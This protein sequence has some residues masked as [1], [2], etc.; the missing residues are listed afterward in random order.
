MSG[1]WQGRG[2]QQPTWPVRRAHW[3][4]LPA[5]WGSDGAVSGEGLW[6]LGRGRAHTRRYHHLRFSGPEMPTAGP[7]RPE[8]SARRSRRCLCRRR[9]GGALGPAA[10]C[11]HAFWSPTEI[12]NSVC[13][14]HCPVLCGRLLLSG[15][16]ENSADSAA[17]A[18]ADPGAAPCPRRGGS[19]SAPL[20]GRMHFQSV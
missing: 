6:K 4:S 10:Q 1:T 17:S 11:E 2:V 12:P 19:S 9:A 16:S 7:A 14:D 20:K 13:I 5:S 8:S 15:A 18:I 3:P